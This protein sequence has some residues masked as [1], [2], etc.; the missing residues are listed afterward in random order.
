MLRDEMAA[1]VADGSF[2]IWSVANIDDTVAIF[3]RL[4]VGQPGDNG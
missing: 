4:D 2:H 1:A 3:T